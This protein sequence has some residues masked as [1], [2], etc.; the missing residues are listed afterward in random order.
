MALALAINTDTSA[1]ALYDVLADGETQTG[2][3]HK[4]VELDEAFENGGLLVLGNA[5]TCILAI[6]IIAVR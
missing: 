1:T 6:E 3:L 2:T 5:G 4:V